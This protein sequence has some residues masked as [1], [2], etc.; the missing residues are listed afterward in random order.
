VKEVLLEGQKRIEAEHVRTYWETGH[1]IQQHILQ[2]NGRAE[3]GAAIMKRLSG[4]LAIGYDLLYRCLK[5]AQSYPDFKKVVIR[6]Q[7]SWTHYKKLITVSD[8]GER[9]RLEDIADKGRWSAD[10]LAA[11]IKASRAVEDAKIPDGPAATPVELLVPLRGA[12]YTYRVTERRSVSG[13]AEAELLLD[14]GFATSRNVEARLLT[15]FSDGDIVES[16]PKE[17][18][19]RFIKSGRTQRDL[20]T[21]LA[22][23][24]KV[25]DGDTLKVRIDLGFDTW[26]FQTLRLRG[27][28]C[29][30]LGT[31]AGDAAKAF[32]Q[33]HLKA[34]SSV[35]IRS[36]RSDKYDRYLA[37]VFLP[38][39]AG[40]DPAA[41]VFLS[42]LLLEAGHASLWEA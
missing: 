24:E 21:Y 15:S 10:E 1:Y 8:A 13:G 40:A 38:Q 27:I 42:T 33:S 31:K 37:D 23:V 11:R 22:Y 6:P 14:L 28:D 34:A 18:S 3:Y 29:P 4:D 41:D 30:E 7:F 36:S 39:G 35:I 16:C 12:L 25:V 32:V 5:F 19:Y 20:Y 9:T 17:D 26:T 2:N